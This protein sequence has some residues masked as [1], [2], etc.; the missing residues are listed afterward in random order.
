MAAR[1]AE[2]LADLMVGRWVERSVQLT[3]APSAGQMVA[4]TA[5]LLAAQR[6]EVSA[7]LMG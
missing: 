1:T 5:G 6:V 4:A 3:V 2:W 7:A